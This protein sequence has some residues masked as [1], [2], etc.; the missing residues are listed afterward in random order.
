MLKSVGFIS[1]LVVMG[2]SC[3]IV[4]ARETQ[5]YEVRASSVWGAV[6]AH[7]TDRGGSFRVSVA[8]EAALEGWRLTRTGAARPVTAGRLGRVFRFD[9]EQAGA[10]EPG[11]QLTVLLATDTESRPVALRL[12]KDAAVT[13]TAAT[14][15]RELEFVP[16]PRRPFNTIV[17]GLYI[18][19]GESY[20]LGD[21]DGARRTLGKALELDPDHTR[22]R[23]L[24]ERIEREESGG[25]HAAGVRKAED[26][27][28]AG[29][30][31][32]ALETLEGVLRESDGHPDALALKGRI[33]ASL[34]AHRTREV[35][36]LLASASRAESAGERLQA[37]GLYRNVLDMEP[38]N[39]EAL[40]GIRRVTRDAA[41]PGGGTAPSR[42]DPDR[43]EKA[44]RAYNLGLE[45]YRKND[46]DGARK[47]WQE[48]LEYQP[49]HYQAKRNLER[50]AAKEAAK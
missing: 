22:S 28:A 3:G 4:R 42:V 13:G 9:L 23:R 12:S 30:P 19:A 10:I 24:L 26:Q 39:G 44:D 11:M 20:R 48:T 2:L 41:T 18:Q 6:R 15:E 17:G 47:F 40:R 35:S 36:R 50:L 7:V 34:T 14:L 38:D 31:E 49:G 25:R 21:R 33:E 16:E 8:S 45:C 27:W 5:R 32:I 43:V 37:E 46:L 1:A 29:D